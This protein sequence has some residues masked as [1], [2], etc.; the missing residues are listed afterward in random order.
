MFLA[1]AKKG[2]KKKNPNR[3]LILHARTLSKDKPIINMDKN[4]NLKQSNNKISSTAIK[5]G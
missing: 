3:A 1:T 5:T 4:K 2:K